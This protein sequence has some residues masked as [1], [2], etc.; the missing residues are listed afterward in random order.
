MSILSYCDSQETEEVLGLP[1]TQNFTIYKGDT[2]FWSFSVSSINDKP[3]DLTLYSFRMQIRE[4]EGKEDTS[5]ILYEVDGNNDIS[6]GQTAEGIKEGVFDEFNLKIS[7]IETEKFPVGKFY[8]DLE[9]TDED[10]I[11]TTYFRGIIH[12]I[13]DITK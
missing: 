2:F 12:V 7:N 8:Y 4:G 11:V 10:G 13:N 3:L 5:E 6:L 9:F 1:V